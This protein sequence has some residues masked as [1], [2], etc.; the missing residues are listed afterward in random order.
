MWPTRRV[1]PG[2]ARSPA[3]VDRV[4]AFADVQTPGVGDWIAAGKLQV[5]SGSVAT[6]YFDGDSVSLDPAQVY[7]WTGTANASTSYI[8]HAAAASGTANSVRMLGNVNAA[9]YSPAG[10]YL[11][12]DASA[13]AA[14]IWIPNGAQRPLAFPGTPGNAS[15]TAMSRLGMSPGEKHMLRGSCIRKLA[16]SA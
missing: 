5:E 16:H 8:R 11:M 1:L 13:E 10:V 7:G 9:V 4:V 3:S 2:R 15:G 6:D 14:T 12:A